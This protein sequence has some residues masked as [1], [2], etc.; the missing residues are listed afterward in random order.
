MRL[1]LLAALLLL[2]LAA[3]ATPADPAA[4]VAAVDHALRARDV[5]ALVALVHTEGMSESDQAQAAAGLAGLLPPADAEPAVVTADRLPDLIDIGKP[6]VA[7]GR[8]I[9]L[10]AAPAGIIRVAH[11]EGRASI[12]TTLPYVQVAQGCLLAGRRITDLGWTGPADRQLGFTFADDYPPHPTSIHIRY[13]ASGVVLTDTL[14][15]HSGVIVGQHIEEFTIRD[16]PPNF[17]GRLVL[18][19]GKEEIFRSDPI[20]GQSTYTYRRAA[21]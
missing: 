14:I 19:E 21:P 20:V 16:L 6:L 7:H 8:R 3:L 2:D 15:H 10:T 1:R 5:S 13:N 4:L 18:R 12:N 17:K 11:K 9:E